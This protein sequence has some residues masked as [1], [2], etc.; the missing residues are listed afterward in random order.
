MFG[1]LIQAF[2]VSTMTRADLGLSQI[3]APAYILSCKISFLTFG[4]AEYV[5]QGLLVVLVCILTKKI[6]L[7]YAFTFVTVL[8]YGAV[9]DLFNWLWQSLGVIPMWSRLL[10]FAVGMVLTA[11]SVS[12]FFHTYLSPAAYDF[13]VKQVADAKH[14][15]I[16][17]FKLG[18]DAAFLITAVVLSLLFFRKLVGVSIG[19]VLMALVNGHIIRFFSSQ[20][21]KHV[22][23][24]DRFP[25]LAAYFE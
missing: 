15:N 24:F 11:L 25:K 20:I 8:I 19:T 17:K 18:F 22:E 10:L 14:L 9:L 21:E 6:K 12:L 2:A 3:V 4:Q 5:V 1:L 23:W 7:S 13:F 16:N